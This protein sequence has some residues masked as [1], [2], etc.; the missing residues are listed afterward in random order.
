MAKETYQARVLSRRMSTSRVLETELEL[1][2]PPEFHFKAGQ[3]VTI[4]VADKVL[5]SYSIAS[6][7]RDARRVLMIVDLSPRG[8]GSAYFERLAEG[9]AV[10]FQGPYGA[11]CLRE[12]TD[13]ELLLVATGTGIAPIRGILLDLQ[14]RGGLERPITLHY[15][16]RHRGDLVFH[17][18]FEALAARYPSLAYHPTLTQPPH[19]GW[20]GLTGRVTAHLPHYVTRVEGVT[21]FLCGSKSMLKDVGE[22][23]IGLGMDRKKIK[24]E[25]FF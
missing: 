13:R 19:D 4:P 17:E 15:G 5:R 22:I 18:E 9:D 6:P 11:F 12:D 24:K 21:A 16:C 10:S 20:T 2:A 7:P 25:Q 23:L 8:P 1:V 14:E 3:F